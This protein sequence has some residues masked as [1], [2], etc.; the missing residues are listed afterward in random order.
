MDV[1]NGRIRQH[2]VHGG[3]DG[4]AQRFSGKRE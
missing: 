1:Q 2:G 4:R 3:F